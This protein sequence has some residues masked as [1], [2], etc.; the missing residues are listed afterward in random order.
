MHVAQHSSQVPVDVFNFFQPGAAQHELHKRVLHEI[1]GGVSLLVR[2]AHCP[3]EQTFVTLGEQLFTLLVWLCGHSALIE[4]SSSRLTT[5]FLFIM[6]IYAR[7]SQ[8]E[9]TLNY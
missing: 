7:R 4:H 9:R 5:E 2:Q 1:R 6:C 3:R 8:K